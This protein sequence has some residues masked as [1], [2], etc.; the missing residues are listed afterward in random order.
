LIGAIFTW[1][2]TFILVVAV[3]IAVGGFFSKADDLT[4]FSLSGAGK[5]DDHVK[6]IRSAGQ[7]RL[8]FMILGIV[9]GVLP[10]LIGFLLQ[11]LGQ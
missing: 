4:A 2:G 3:F 10:I 8:G 11:T 1:A 6:N 7:I 5:M 9:N